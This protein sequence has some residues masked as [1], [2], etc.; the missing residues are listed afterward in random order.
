MQREVP[1]V[2]PVEDAFGRLYVFGAV[3]GATHLVL[4]AASVARLMKPPVQL[5]SVQLMAER[6]A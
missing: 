6:H 1:E 5:K 3:F 2:V 4:E